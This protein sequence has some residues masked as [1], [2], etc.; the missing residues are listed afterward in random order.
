[1]SNDP[2]IVAK[3]RELNDQLRTTATG[4]K[5]VI[6]GAL[7]GQPL[8]E[9]AAALSHV[10]R[11][12]KFDEGNDPYGEHDF[13][14]FEI[15]GQRYHWKIDY[16]ALDEMSG[17]EHPEDPNVTVRVLSIYYAEDQ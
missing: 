11:F 5:I 15:D 2:A 7:S 8:S 1:M 4:G 6:V 9:H 17:S 12:D 16:F 10:R 14:A 13:G 3:I